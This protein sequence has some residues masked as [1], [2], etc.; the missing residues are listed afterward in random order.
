MA[1]GGDAPPHTSLDLPVFTLKSKRL[2]EVKVN[3]QKM[4]FVV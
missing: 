1:G 2:I 4:E 3:K